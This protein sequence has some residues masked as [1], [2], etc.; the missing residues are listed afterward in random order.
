MT[1]I[2]SRSTLVLALCLGFALPAAGQLYGGQAVDAS[3]REPLTGLDVRLLHHRD[4]LPQPVIVDST[5]TDER[6]LFE[7]RLLSEGVYQTE[8][9]PW[10]AP[11]SLGSIDTVG[12]DRITRRYLVPVPMA[13]AGGAIAGATRSDATPPVAAARAPS[14]VGIAASTTLGTVIGGAA[15]FVVAELR[16]GRI[17]NCSATRSY[18]YFPAGAVIGAAMGAGASA[19]ATPCR[20]GYLRGVAGSLLGSLA[21]SLVAGEGMQRQRAGATAG[22]VIGGAGLVA[23]CRSARLR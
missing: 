11:Y 12:S 6:G 8:F 4:G 1:K 16:C 3:S 21:G 5:R 9:G 15:G 18:P 23:T 2:L 20:W 13:R 17:R 14:L 22:A 10:Q 19:S 7:F